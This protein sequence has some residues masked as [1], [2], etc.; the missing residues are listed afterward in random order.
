MPISGDNDIAA[1]T[2]SFSMSV[3]CNSHS[4]YCQ[5]S[6]GSGCTGSVV[7]KGRVSSAH[8]Y[9]TLSTFTGDDIVECAILP[10]M[11]VDYVTTGGTFSVEIW[12]AV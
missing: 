4:G 3:R 5:V 10:D 1:G 8:D 7:L 2:G 6:F 11:K 9:V 12:E